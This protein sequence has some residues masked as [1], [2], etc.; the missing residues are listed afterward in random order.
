M[1]RPAHS[2]SH[3]GFDNTLIILYGVLIFI[4]WLTLYSTS[5][6]P[7]TEL[8]LF[9]LQTYYGRQLIWI[10]TSVCFAIFISFIDNK[11]IQT[12]AFPVYIAMV[13]INLV[14]PLVATEVSGARSWIKF[15]AFSVQPIEF[16]KFATALA[17]AKFFSEG[18][19]TNQKRWMWIGASVIILIPLVLAL[20]QND[21]GSALVFASFIILFYRE[22]L[23]PLI[24]IAG[25]A[26]VLIFLCT[27]YFNELYTIAAIVVVFVASFFFNANRRAIYRNL[28][29]FAIA[30]GS[31]FAVNYAYNDILQQHQRQ[32]IDTIL[33]KSIDPKGAD[34]NLNQSKIAIG[35]GG[36]L[37]KG[38]LKGTQTK[39][40]FVPEQ[41]TDFIFCGI[42]EEWGFVGCVIVISLYLFLII[43]IILLSEKQRSNFVRTYGYGVASILFFHLA[44]NI[45]M[46]IGIVP[47][48]GIP[49]PFISYGGSSLWGFTVMLFLFI[50]LQHNNN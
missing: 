31:V 21:T 26:I 7:G 42:G 49:L 45:G 48:I 19:T 46:T 24:I 2:N 17:L 20:L 34:F 37:G 23:N 1:S 8:D 16:A 47:V 15:G 12:Y 39:L 10:L 14:V 43:R 40:N 41:R 5:Y 50:R 44:I 28:I 33:G 13:L 9:S 35:S 6:K 3:K 11:L 32:R 38:Y 22:G 18:K 29:I 25:I 30:I 4:G 27:I 36:F